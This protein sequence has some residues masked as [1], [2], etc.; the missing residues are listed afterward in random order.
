MIR[1]VILQD[2]T[3]EEWNDI[4]K[5]LHRKILKAL[6]NSPVEMTS[7]KTDFE[8][9]GRYT[10][11]GLTHIEI[12]Y[13]VYDNF[14]CNGVM[15]LPENFDETKT[16]PAVVTIHGTNARGKYSLMDL[17][18]RPERAYAIELAKRG[19]VTFSP[20]QYGFGTAM[21][22]EEFSHA[23]ENF[24]NT[25][26]DWSLFGRRLIEH[27]RAVDVLCQLEYIDSKK[28]GAMGNSLGGAAVMYL[29]ALDERI[30]AS[31]ISTGISPNVTNMYRD[32]SRS[33]SDIVNINVLNEMKTDGVPSWELNEV[34][35]LCAPRAIMCIEPFN[36]PY[37]P[38]VMTSIE[39][40]HKA[41]EVYGLQECPSKIS[42]YVH[43]DGHDTV[44]TVR[45]MAYDWLER[46]L[47]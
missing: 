15:V 33:G 46:F 42:L 38:Y 14:R 44:D 39:C 18:N 12:S 47:K 2:T 40:V 20:D 19:F 32:F 4:R 31:V 1:P 16:Y 5:K 8:E 13:H 43:G 26:P 35:A 24:Y 17:E 6:G 25:Y 22:N 34:L 45:D 41:S 3:K 7:C 30:S 23:Y 21:E 37:N 9:I 28:I 11:Y 10:N 36:D 29:T 27:I